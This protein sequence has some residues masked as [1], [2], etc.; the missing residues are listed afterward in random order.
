M[1]RE[2]Q[3]AQGAMSA[4]RPLAPPPA[5]A[6]DQPIYNTQAVVQL[7]GVPAP[8]VRAWER[9]YGAPKPARLAGGQRL[10]SEWDVAVV[11]WLRDCTRQGLSVSHAVR[12]L[13][14]RQ[15]PAAAPWADEGRSLVRLHTEL[16]ARLEA[17]DAAGA[18]RVLS[19]AFA[20]HPV[21]A[22]CLELIQPVLVEIGERWHQG[23]LSVAAE[24]FATGL[25]RRHLFALLR[26]YEGAASG[27]PL[28]LACAAEELHEMGLLLVALFLSRRGW[29][30]VYLGPDVPPTALREAAQQL[31]PR[32][33]VLSASTVETAAQ[34][35]AAIAA[36]ETLPAPRPPVA[37][38][39][40]V[41]EQ[42]RSLLGQ[43]PATYL[44]ADAR[45][46]ASRV[47]GLLDGAD[48]VARVG[49]PAR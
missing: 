47:H 42:N 26:A 3:G 18:E 4:D 5:A 28:L 12:L 15:A 39:G 49:D 8:T 11:R 16:L 27:A 25:L 10:Y 43:L 22:V 7:T 24:H 13:Q 45:E 31:R 46:A 34:L 23:T 17:F 44:G 35:R 30:V 9:R 32:L 37:Y 1:N 29:P 40:R 14:A 33:V 20:L 2:R 6:S 19:E 48:A 41:F 21:E 36:L 38:G